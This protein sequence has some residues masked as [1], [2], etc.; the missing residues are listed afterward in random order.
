M[1]NRQMQAKFER[2]QREKGDFARNESF[3]QYVARY[4]ANKPKSADEIARIERI[5]RLKAHW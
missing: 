5:Q 3:V 2:S 4:E 1:A